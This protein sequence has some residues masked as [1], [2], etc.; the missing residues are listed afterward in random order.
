MGDLF[1]N[2]FWDSIKIP[3]TDREW[4]KAYSKA[5]RQVLA[6]PSIGFILPSAVEAEDVLIARKPARVDADSAFGIVVRMEASRLNP[7][8]TPK[9]QAFFKGSDKVVLARIATLK[10]VAKPVIGQLIVQPFFLKLYG[11]PYGFNF[12]PIQLNGIFMGSTYA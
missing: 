6:H 4:L 9:W 11:Q 8:F 12:W 2:V 7:D 10:E 1:T 3:E 5:W